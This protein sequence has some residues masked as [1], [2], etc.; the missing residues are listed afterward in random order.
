MTAFLIVTGART[1]FRKI[2]GMFF[3]AVECHF[4][5]TISQ[6]SMFNTFSKSK[7]F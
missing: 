6:W 1:A 5:V 4:P 2:P 3:C 7:I